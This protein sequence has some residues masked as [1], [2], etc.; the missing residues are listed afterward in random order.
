MSLT[1][2]HN[3]VAV[4]P[5]AAA[6][7]LGSLVRSF[8]APDSLTL[9]RAIAFD[10]PTDWECLDSIQLLDDGVTL[11]EGW[12]VSSERVASADEEYILYTCVGLRDQAHSTPFRRS[13]DGAV[14][15]RVV[16]N[17]PPEEEPEEYG[18]VGLPGVE[19]TVG[20]ILAD[21]LDAM[22]S[23]LAGVLG[24]GSPGSGHVAAE[25][26]ALAVVPG[27]VVLSAVSV[28]EAI[29]EVLRWA[30]DFGYWIDPA[31][32]K[33]RFFDF[34]SLAAKEIPGVDGSVLRQQ[35]DF[36]TAGC[37]SAC[38]VE[39][40]H[41]LVDILEELTP[42]WDR[43]LEATWTSELAAK[44][45]DTYG[46]VWR[47]FATAEPA[48]AGGA[49]VPQRFAGEGDVVVEITA[50]Q[51]GESVT[52]SASASVFDD[53]K[54]LLDTFARQWNPAT[55][56]FEPAT[57]HARFT[58][59]KGCISGRYPASGHTGTAHSRRG[60]SRELLI[61]DDHYAKKTIK[62]TVSTVASATQFA[63]PYELAR[64]GELAGLAI[65]FNGD[66]IEHAI[67][68]NDLASITLQAAP[69]DPIE[70]GDTF[71]IRVQD[72]TRK[73]FDGGT[74]SALEKYAKEMLER[75]MDEHIVGRVSLAGLDWSVAL[76][77]KID[78]TGTNDP[79][80]ATLGAILAAVEHDLAHERTVLSLTTQR[81]PGLLG[82]IAGPDAGD[83]RS[84]LALDPAGGEPWAE[85]ERRRAR[86]RR[87]AEHDRQLRR[88]WKR[89]RAR[90]APRGGRGDPH[91]NDGDGAGPLTG[92]G[93]WIDIANKVVRHIGPGPV[94]RTLGGSGHFI[95]WIS[96]DAKKH[97][98]DAGVGTFS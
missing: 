1:L 36:S 58:Y 3:G 69:A 66:G 21:L 27:K 94:D 96:L 47:L 15:A 84:V 5:A 49:V 88:L 92:D 97:V 65:E 95:E 23:E 26:D 68:D 12:I 78:F 14:T 8:A 83:T 33:A 44:E 81:A 17:C 46:K 89:F 25:L 19:S 73:L 37:F 54:L 9:R 45:P 29:G 24:D 42:A 64:P 60:L 2:K 4:D 40:D 52:S 62:G 71:A 41:E 11:F 75:V 20:E 18:H 13:I 39:G 50:D 86:D 28:D 30:P 53:T 7:E 59:E 82:V 72:D 93:T 87:L 63:T 34:R 79:E 10:E 43:G 80:Y 51:G 35:L 32:H 98:V 61:L 48:P 56:A 38:T 70:V 76:G 57:V 67:A 55:R 90:R 74:L 6:C 16:Y 91:V 85:F 22:A 31:T 77:Q